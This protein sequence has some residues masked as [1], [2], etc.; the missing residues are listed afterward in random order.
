MSSRSS[1]FA[2][3]LLLG[4][5][6]CGA[7]PRAP[8][9]L[10]ESVRSFNDGVR[11]ERFSIAAVRVPPRERS[12]FVEDM[13]ERAE[14]LKITDYEVVRVDE[15]GPREARVQVKLSWYRD[16]GG[17]AARDPRACRPGSATARPG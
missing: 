11:W 17:H 10:T 5:G 13:D 1:L 15:R 2:A 3:A 12:Q 7:V 9:T 6:A 16:L 4:L 14:D 8:D